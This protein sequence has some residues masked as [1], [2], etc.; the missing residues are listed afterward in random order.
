MGRAE[1][2]LRF[3]ASWRLTLFVLVALPVVASLSAWQ[4]NRA[5]EAERFE[6]HLAQMDAAEPRLITEL[7]AP[8]EAP[9]LLPVLLEGR[10]LAG[11]RIWRDNRTRHG[12]V[13]YDLLAPF[14]ADGLEQQWVLVQLGW[15][16]AGSRRS[17]LP[18][19]TLPS[20]PV[21]IRGRLL[22]QRPPGPLFGPNLERLGDDLRLQQVDLEEIAAALEQTLFERIVVADP[23]AP[24]V[25]AWQ[26]E[27]LRLSADRHR[28]Y[29]MQWAGL[30]LVL[31][32]GWLFASFRRDARAASGE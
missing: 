18:E 30:G 19:V 7:D 8:A 10:Y 13:G 9:D 22:P 16:A 15:V 3:V 32:V 17:E 2:G 20:T 26:F 14:V 27:A 25:Q 28:G 12:R 4:W 5:A 11:P 6:A 23:E 29:A 24:G 1:G 21:V 31:V